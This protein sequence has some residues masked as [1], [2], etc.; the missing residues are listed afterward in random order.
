MN[1]NIN[2]IEGVYDEA[3]RLSQK[4]DD[5]RPEL[6]TIENMVLKT[7]EELGELATDVLKLK[8]YKVNSENKDDIRANAREEAV[9]GIL[10][11]LNICK[12]L[13]I[14]KEE[15][16]RIATFKLDKW[17]SKHLN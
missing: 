12:N 11:Y 17:D 6:Q 13:G 1:S 14:S 16:I 3:M 4:A 15:F 8:G 7:M 5:I 2:T 9:D 10:I